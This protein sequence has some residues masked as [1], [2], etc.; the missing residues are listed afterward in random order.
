[1]KTKLVPSTVVAVA[2]LFGAAKGLAQ[3]VPGVDSLRKGL[4]KVSVQKLLEGEPAITTTLT[5]AITEVTFL[6]DFEPLDWAPLGR[7][8]RGTEGGFRLTG[9]GAFAMEVESYCLRAGSYA[10]GRGDGYLYARLK[11]P[12]AKIVH[13]V[14]RR[15]QTNPQ[16]AQRQIQALLWAILA[17]TKVSDMSSDLLLTAKALLTPAEIYEVNGGALGLVPREVLDKAIAAASPTLRPALEAEDRVRSLVS[18]GDA[19][20]EQLERAAVLV[21]EPPPGKGSRD[22]PRGRWSCHAAGY[23]IRYLPYGYPQTVVWVYAPE[24]FAIETDQLGRITSVAGPKGW[25]LGLDYSAATPTSVAGETGLTVQRMHSVSMELTL[26]KPR[27][28][29]VPVES[30]RGGWTLLGS[31]PGPRNDATSSSSL[32]GLA[33]RVV[34]S[35]K[36]RREIDRLFGAASVAPAEP[37]IQRIIAL[38]HLRMALRDLAPSSGGA[39]ATVDPV[40][41]VTRAWMSEVGRTLAGRAAG[42]RPAAASSPISPSTAAPHAR[43]PGRLALASWLVPLAAAPQDQGGDDDYYL[44]DLSDGAGQPGNT[45]LQ[46]EGLS[47]RGTKRDDSCAGEY[48]ACR[49]SAEEDWYTAVTV[50]CVASVGIGGDIRECQRQANRQHTIDRQGCATIAKHCLG[51]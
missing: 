27:R 22:V 10:P 18:Q 7:Q 23:F 44:I 47:N 13:N 17:R 41:F 14:L 35:A 49:D 30:W 20:Y 29:T 2:L 31:A 40:E 8:P 34:R 21:G 43:R 50:D 24:R 39:A 25:R 51:L 48:A 19:T 6:D 46:R 3:K 11:G 12:R 45:G 5:D 38:A 28:V 36:H 15:A 32:P 26:E 16:I 4:D 33:D 37:A 42:A 1:M 9:G